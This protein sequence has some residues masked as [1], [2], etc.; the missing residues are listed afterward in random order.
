MAS[1][2]A[3]RQSVVR[4]LIGAVKRLPPAQLSEFKRQFSRWQ[5][6]NGDDDREE[7]ALIQTCKARLPAA[8]RRRLNKLVAKSERGA[9]TST[10]LESY[11]T[12]M[13]RAERLDATR[14]AALTRLAR[15]WGKP[16]GAVM[17]AIGW[18]G[19]EDEA[20]SRPARTTKTGPRTR[21]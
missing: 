4:Q 7:A 9:L 19:G 17:S 8:V 14:L 1:A 6:Q 2:Q 12:L 13:G 16:V 10:D 5:L 20:E 15:L 3:S 21:P 18:E 11:R